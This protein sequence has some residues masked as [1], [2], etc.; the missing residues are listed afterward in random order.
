MLVAFCVTLACLLSGI[1]SAPLACDILVQTLD[2]LDPHYL[3]GRWAL[4]ASSMTLPYELE[5]LK[6]RGSM[7]V[8]VSNFTETSGY[9]YTQAN[10]LDERCYYLPHNFKIEN[11]TITY[12][13]DNFSVTCSFLIHP[14]LTV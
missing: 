8:Y 7:A 13:L 3:Q 2:H 5:D 10:R 11:G 9:S 6:F 14:A 12:K 1:H 4:V